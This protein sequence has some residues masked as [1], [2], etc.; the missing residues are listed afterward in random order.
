MDLQLVG[1]I[2]VLLLA[3]AACYVS[4]RIYNA[5]K[6]KHSAIRWLAISLALMFVRRML[7]L[8]AD[9]DPANELAIFSISFDWIMLSIISITQIYALLKIGDILLELETDKKIVEELSEAKDNLMDAITHEL[10]TPLSVIFTS[11]EML[12]N[13][14]P[15]AKGSKM[16]EIFDLAERNSNRLAHTIEQILAVKKVDGIGLMKIAVDL[17][18]AARD[19]YSEYAPLAK[20]KGI[21][22]SLSSSKAQI[23]G[24]PGLLRIALSS[25][26]S[27]AVKF[28][29]KGSIRVS[30]SK[31]G[32]GYAFSV[33][34]TGPG[35]SPEDQKKVFLK[36]FKADPKASGS[37]MGLWLAAEII[38]KHGGEVMMESR[39][40]KGTRFNVWLPRGG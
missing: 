20:A 17:D 38:K 21:M 14:M 16:A 40:G 29:E 25:F 1:S 3:G 30:L 27:N 39:P 11:L 33:R 22:F 36:F 23:I 2:V 6:L 34:D 10:K 8:Y 7:S 31:E 24:D 13:M 4:L 12:H 18:S 5:H 26:V 15:P 35:I 37:G 28:T 9:V 19:I 32:S